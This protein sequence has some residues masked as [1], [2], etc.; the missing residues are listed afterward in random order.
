MNVTRKYGRHSTSKQYLSQ[1]AQD[2]ACSEYIHS[3][4][5]L[6]EAE[7]EMYYDSAY[8]GST[9][10]ADRP[11]GKALLLA[12]N[13]GDHVVV[14]ALDRLGRDFVDS[15]QT[16]RLFHKRGI[17]VHLLDML[18]VARMDPDDPQGE[19]MLAQLAAVGQAMRKQIAVKTK[20]ALDYKRSQ[21]FS[22]CGLAPLGFKKVPN[23]AWREDWTPQQ[24]SQS[25]KFLLVPHPQGVDYFNKAYTMV[26]GGE[27]YSITLYHLRNHPD[28]PNWSYQRLYLN[29]KKENDKRFKAQ[30]KQQRKDFFGDT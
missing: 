19:L 2:K 23:P 12:S 8:S 27:K 20:Q 17:F 16:V 5:R 13:A 11:A 9:P 3:L 25:G 6:P 10:F 4:P 15:I 28:A 30:Q 14:A 1:G 24:K 7:V 18:F 22:S 26:C 21:G 29:V